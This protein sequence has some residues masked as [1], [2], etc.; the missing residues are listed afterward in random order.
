MPILLLSADTSSSACDVSITALAWYDHAVFSG[1]A[2]TAGL[3]V[4]SVCTHIC[5]D[6]SAA[7]AK[8]TLY[9]VQALMPT[10]AL[11]IRYAK[12]TAHTPLSAS[13]IAVTSITVTQAAVAQVTVL[14]LA[15]TVVA[16]AEMT[17]T[18]GPVVSL[19]STCHILRFAKGSIPVCKCNVN[20]KNAN[21]YKCC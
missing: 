10:A 5:A 7:K 1:N 19:L 16:V 13:F 12:H 17:V 9:S 6:T 14:Q 18:L 8:C 3:F 4:I 2:H 11:S 21:K 15:V 20:K